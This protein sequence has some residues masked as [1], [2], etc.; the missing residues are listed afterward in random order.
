MR[1]PPGRKLRW[2][3]TLREDLLSNRALVKGNRAQLTQLDK[4]L[5]DRSGAQEQVKGTE[6]QVRGCRTAGDRRTATPARANLVSRRRHGYTRGVA[7]VGLCLAVVTGLGFTHSAGGARTA[8]QPDYAARPSSVWL[9]ELQ[10][11]KPRLHNKAVMALS[12]IRPVAPGTVAALSDLVRGDDW[13]LRHRALM[14]LGNLGPEAASALP[15][16]VGA[17]DDGN[18][19]VRRMA[20]SALRRIGASTPEARLALVAALVHTDDYVRRESRYALQGLGQEAADV[21]PTLGALLEHEDDSVRYAAL[22]VLEDAG[23]DAAVPVLVPYLRHARAD[24]RGGAANAL[25]SYGPR[26]EAAVPILI[27]MLDD[28]QTRYLAIT[29]LGKIGPPAKPAVPRL[30]AMFG[31]S[32][33]SRELRI[34]VVYALRGIGPAPN[35]VLPTFRAELAAADYSEASG[36]Y[37][38]ALAAAIREI[39]GVH[40]PALVAYAGQLARGLT[41]WNAWTRVEAARALASLGPAASLALPELREALREDSEPKIRGLAADALGAMGAAAQPA[42]TDLRAAQSDE[43]ERVR[44]KAALAIANIEQSAE[45][46]IPPP[47]PEPQP[48]E[49]VAEIAQDV[50]ALSTSGR[51]ANKAAYRLLARG[52]ESLPALHAALLSPQSSARQRG[53]L[54]RLLSDLGDPSS[55]D[56]IL[57]SLSVHSQ[58][59]LARVGVLRALAAIAQTPASFEFAM[60]LLQDPQ[61]HPRVRRQALVYFA[62][63]RDRRARKWV[64]VFMED[65]D[66][67]LQASALYLA[68]MLGDQGVVSQIT[69]LL[70]KR[71]HSSYRY[72]LLLALAELVDPLEFEQQTETLRGHQQEYESALRLVRFRTGDAKT[73]SDLSHDMLM[74]R[75]PNERRTAMRD[76]VQRQAFGE[77]TRYLDQWMFVP[78][79]VRTTVVSEL[80]RGGYRLVEAKRRL[81]IERDRHRGQAAPPVS[82]AYRK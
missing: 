74:S 67:Q 48:I 24:I 59:G 71:P 73:R 80:Y 38:H 45:V 30:M 40:D 32:D 72:G 10:S 66:P 43:H 29:T 39:G 25:A 68:A 37:R 54:I 47:A 22:Q 31:E 35:G 26:A 6:R 58:E 18:V 33:P 13:V 44:K 51:A 28:H 2:L 7:L 14:V 41:H 27:L 82:Q 78:A 52:A 42:L 77:L 65:A 50:M 5:W 56:I 70:R 53:Q 20:V 75:F 64:E 12:K 49:P 9:T 61:E 4:A 79:R 1:W 36:R 19:H 76:M 23:A 21:A 15:V 69:E 63:Q 34:R 16:V 60:G 62:Q 11:P 17:L 81:V 8:R 3:R 57:R 55:V 46:P